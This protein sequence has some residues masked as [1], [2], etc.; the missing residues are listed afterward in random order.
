MRR[1]RWHT[2]GV[3]QRIERAAGVPGL[4][5]ILSERLAPADLRSLP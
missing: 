4:T 2:Q 1:E 3:L 5:A